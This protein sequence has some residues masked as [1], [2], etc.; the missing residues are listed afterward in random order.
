MFQSLFP[1]VIKCIGNRYI[2]K[3]KYIYLLSTLSSID[4]NCILSIQ[5]VCVLYYMSFIHKSNKNIAIFV[6]KYSMNWIIDVSSICNRIPNIT[7]YLKIYVHCAYIFIVSLCIHIPTY[8]N[9]YMK[10]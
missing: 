2:L 1:L 8:L 10:T 4:A 5:C 7:L 3:I 9:N 6:G